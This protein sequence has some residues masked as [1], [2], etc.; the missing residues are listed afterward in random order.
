M[1]LLAIT[2]SLLL[3]G[4]QGQEIYMQGG[5]SELMQRGIHLSWSIPTVTVP[6]IHYPMA[7][8]IGPPR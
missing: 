6:E 7:G 4:C 2:L 1:N 3:A 8:K 5:L